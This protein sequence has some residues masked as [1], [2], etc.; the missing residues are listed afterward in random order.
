MVNTKKH[1]NIKKNKFTKHKIG[2]KVEINS[3]PRPL[4]ETVHSTKHST[5]LSAP[6]SNSS[7]NNKNNTTN[8]DNIN[9][10]LSLLDH[11]E[12]KSNET[13]NKEDDERLSKIL[14]T[15]TKDPKPRRNLY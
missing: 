15:I 10:L 11:F 9:K 12:Q 3:Q 2:G 8:Y 7:G 6:N 14:S 13:D 4:L 5:K 1:N